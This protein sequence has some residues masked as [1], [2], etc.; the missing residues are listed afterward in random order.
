MSVGRSG[1]GRTGPQRGTIAMGLA[2]KTI[3]EIVAERRTDKAQVQAQRVK[4][5]DR[6]AARLAAVATHEAAITALC[7]A[8]TD[9][10]AARQL[11]LASFP[12]DDAGHE[13][14]G[15]AVLAARR[16]RFEAALVA[17]GLTTAS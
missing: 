10:E 14:F 2:D 7:E 1:S 5:K 8:S 17:L 12:Q 9:P 3:E 13:R 15:A 6:Q 16:Q 4:L 11:W